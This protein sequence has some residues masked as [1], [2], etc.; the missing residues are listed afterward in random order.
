[1]WVEGVVAGRRSDGGWSKLWVAALGPP[2]GPK[3]RFSETLLHFQKNFSDYF[4]LFVEIEYRI[5]KSDLGSFFPVADQVLGNQEPGE[6][7]SWRKRLVGRPHPV[8]VSSVLRV[9]HEVGGWQGSFL[10]V[11]V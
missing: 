4:F 6:S 2:P 5:S 11:F 10:T 3:I 9:G 8:L 7:R 1:M